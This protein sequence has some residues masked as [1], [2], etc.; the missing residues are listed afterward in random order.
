MGQI[1]QNKQ[2]VVRCRGEEAGVLRRIELNS[3]DSDPLKCFLIKVDLTSAVALARL[4]ID[5][6]D[7]FT[8]SHNNINIDIRRGRGR[9]VQG[10]ASFI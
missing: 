3:S 5:F 9:A 4:P 6:V 8:F 10:D 7:A 2:E 1:V